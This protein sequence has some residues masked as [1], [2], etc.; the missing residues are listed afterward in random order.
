MNRHKKT[1][2]LRAELDALF[3]DVR[4]REYDVRVRMNE[5]E[6]GART[7]EHVLAL[8]ESTA[9]S[10]QHMPP[11]PTL[12]D[13]G[14]RAA[15]EREKRGGAKTRS[16]SLSPRKMLPSSPAAASR[17][18]WGGGG[19]RGQVEEASS[20]GAAW[21][22]RAGYIKRVFENVVAALK[23][24]E[25]EQRK[26]DA[27]WDQAMNSLNVQ[28]AQRDEE[29][30]QLRHYEGERCDAE[31][32]EREKGWE[33]ERERHRERELEWERDRANV[34]AARLEAERRER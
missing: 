4:A 30:R 31:Q 14:D 20:D 32:K 21:A 13:V 3:A 8:L 15:R 27:E 11:A 18:G 25:D 33:R 16:L 1:S 6:L 24:K 9:A 22:Q 28:L 12:L 23:T 2:A 26:R 34:D 29:I 7:V 10:H 17:G 19:A 5:V